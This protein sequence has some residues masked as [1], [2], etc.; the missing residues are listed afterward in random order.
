MSHCVNRKL[1]G[2][3]AGAA[4]RY[5]D[6]GRFARF[7]GYA[8]NHVRQCLDGKRPYAGRVLRRWQEWRAANGG[9]GAA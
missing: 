5:P 4:T 2:R 6:I 9:G 3:P 8:P 7:Y 1:R